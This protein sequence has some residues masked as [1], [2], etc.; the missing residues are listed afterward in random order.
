MNAILCRATMVFVKIALDRTYAIVLK[1]LRDD[2]VMKVVILD[3][4]ILMGIIVFF[5][6]TLIVNTKFFSKYGF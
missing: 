4:F 3:F 2:I 1:G 5:I 6:C